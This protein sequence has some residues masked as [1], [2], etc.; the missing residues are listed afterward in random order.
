MQITTKRIIEAPVKKVFDCV[1]HIE[2]YRK[3][4]PHIIDVE[5]LTEQRVGTGTKFRETRMMH[6]KQQ[7]TELE[8]TQYVPDEKV[9]MVNVTNGTTWDTLWTFRQLE[10]GTKMDFCMQASTQSRIAKF[11]LML[12]KPFI[13]YAVTTD[14]DR[15]KQYCESEAE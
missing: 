5:F 7:L 10:N 13:S 3:A 12:L 6:G 9:R 4:Q 1:A 11:A 14:L 2:Q 15:L 8:V